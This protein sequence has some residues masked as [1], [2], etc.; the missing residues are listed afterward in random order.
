MFKKCTILVFSVEGRYDDFFWGGGGFFVKVGLGDFFFL[1][2]CAKF[3]KAT[4][5]FVIS[6]CL[7][8]CLSIRPSARMEQLGLYVTDLDKTCLA[9]YR[10]SVKNTDFIKIR[11]E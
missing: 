3:Q 5:I 1:G 4:V 6:V 8:L 11:Q 7:S 2:A 10:I 9:F